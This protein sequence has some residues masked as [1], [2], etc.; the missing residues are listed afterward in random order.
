V[1]TKAIHYQ[2]G[3]LMKI[4]SFILKTTAVALAAASVA[5]AVVAHLCASL[6]DAD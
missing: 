6:R 3:Q 2:E 1:Y 5:C 4:A